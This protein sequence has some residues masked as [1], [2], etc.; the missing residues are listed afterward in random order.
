[1]KPTAKILVIGDV[2]L[3]RYVSGTVDRVSPEAPVPVVR[4]KKEWS[5]LGG[6]ANVAAN[7]ASLGGQAVLIGLVG[8]DSDG[9]ELE[10]KCAEQSI[11][12]VFFRSDAPTVSKTRIISGQ[13]I[14]R[15]DREERH[16]WNTD[17]LRSLTEALQHLSGVVNIVLVSDYAKG[18]LS[19]EALPVVVD[20]ARK[21]NVRLVVDP[22]RADWLA[23]GHAFLIT[24]NLKELGLAV[25]QSV[26]NDD[27]DVVRAAR[28]VLDG[29]DA[30]HVLVTR[31]EEGMTLVGSGKVLNV[32]AHVQ[33]V[34]DVSGAGDTVLATLGVWLSESKTVSH[35][36][37]AAN[38]AAAIA[39]S[40]RGTTTVSRSEL[41]SI[42]LK[43]T[44]KH[45]QRTEVSKLREALSGKKVVFTNGCFDVLHKGHRKLL[46][47]ARSFGDVLIVGLNSDSS[48]RRLKG[49]ERPLNDEAIRVAALSSLE[50]IDF[51]TIFE[52]DT[53]YGLLQ[54]LIPDVLVKGGDYELKNVIGIDLVGEVRIVGLVEGISTSRM[55]D[56]PDLKQ[57]LAKISNT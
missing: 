50:A 33:E 40:R 30:Q 57:Q 24:P 37:L 9:K 2:M 4:V 7:V 49:E 12:T 31:S 56:L 47:E 44:S 55:I 45:V 48:V 35:S 19:N 26:D 16:V 1:V 17:N 8:N 3:D 23:Y 42:L 52:E 41:E 13:Q 53:P 28:A 36:V 25:G 54:E 46:Q 6:A 39:V 51:V 20:W 11:E 22:K 21:E 38:T 14:V 43:A 29:C 18:T 5:S 32:P 10:R 34:F 27:N 15:V